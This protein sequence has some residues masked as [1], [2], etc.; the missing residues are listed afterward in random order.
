MSLNG[1]RAMGGL[2]HYF[3]WLAVSTMLTACGDAV[4]NNP[5]PAADTNKNTLYSFFAERPKHLDPARSYSSDEYRFIAQIY[6]PPLQYHYLRR[7][8]ELVPLT[9][10][11]VSEPDYLNAAGERLPSD[12][13]ADEIAYTTYDLAIR[14]GINYQPHPAFAENRNG[15]PLYLNLDEGALDSIFCRKRL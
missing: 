9:A 7:P 11:K 5:Y 4:W 3:W 15:Q 1:L 10:E 2:G 13:T 8:Y 12:A 6:E 14:A